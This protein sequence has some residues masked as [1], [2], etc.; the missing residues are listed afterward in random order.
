MRRKLLSRSMLALFSVLV[1]PQVTTA[2]EAPSYARQV[3]PLL[4]KYCVECHNGDK[5][6]GDLDLQTYKSM[7]AGGKK[8]VTIVPGKPDESPLLQRTEGK[9]KPVMPPP[10]SAQPKP[11]EIAVLRAWIAAGA[12]DDGSATVVLPKIKP[13]HL[14]TAPVTAVL[15]DNSGKFLVAG[16]ENWVRLF[17]VAEGT[18]GQLR[19]SVAGSVTAL[20]WEHEDGALAIAGGESG[21]SGELRLYYIPAQVQGVPAHV[22][23]AHDDVIYGLAWSPKGKI[24]ASCGYDRLIKLWDKGAKLLRTLKDHSDTVYGVA[25]SPDGK[26]LASAAA[27]RAVKIW[28]VATGTRLYSLNDSTDWLYAVAWSPDGKHVAAAGVDKSIR[29]WEATASGGKLVHSVFAHEGPVTRL[30]YTSDGKTLYSLSE[31]RSIKSWNTS[32]MTEIKVYDKQPETPLCLAV[33]PDQ[34]QLAVGRYDGALVLL[35]A[36]TGQTQAQPLP[37]KPQPPQLNKLTPAAG[38]RGQVVRVTCEGKNLDDVTELVSSQSG[39]TAKLVAEGQ[40]P[41]TVSFDVTFPAQTPAGSYSLTLK[42]PSGQTSPI[43]FMVDAFPAV[44]EQEPNDSPSTGQQVTLPASIVGSLQRAGDVDFYRFEAKAGQQIGVQVV[45]PAGPKLDPV[46]QL[47]DPAGRIV[48]ESGNGLLGYTCPAAGTYALGIRDQEYRGGSL[49]YRLHVG[50]LP[51]VT[52]VFPLGLQR[53]TEATIRLEGVH[54]GPA[55]TV[56]VNAPA[57]AAPGT[58]IPLT[59]NTPL[60]AALGNPSVVVDE[61][62]QAS[63]AGS[64]L[65]VPTTANGRIATPGAADTWK[66]PAKKGQRLIV[67]VQARRLG[68]PLDSRIEILDAKGQPVPR[69]VLRCLARV[70]TTFRDHDSASPGIRLETWNELAMNDYVLLGN[71]VLRIK[72]LPRNPDDDC[73]FFSVAGQRVGYF[74]TTPTHHSLGS[75]IY[76]LAVHPPG[77]TFPPNGLPVV[78]LYYQNDDGGPGFGK[79]SHLFFDPPADGEY[80]VR[81]TDARGQGGSGY[82]YRLTVRPPR[83]SF[84]VRF[85]P[86]APNVWKGGAVPVTVTADRIDGYDGPIAV[87]LDNLPPGFSAPATTVPAGET[88]TAF[89][90]WANADA[91][92]PAKA[93]L[94]LVARAVIDGTE[95]VRE[96]TGGV[97]E[98]QEPGDIVMTTEQTE[99]TL[100]PGQEVR[101]TAKIE[102]RNG[103]AGRVPLDVRGLPHGVRVLDVGLNGILVTEMDVTRTFVIYCEPWVEPIEHPFVVLARREGKNTEHAAR[104]LLLR[105]TK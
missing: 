3:R 5:M 91:P 65:P 69:A 84:Q 81:L 95:V 86:T 85:N 58:V 2:A 34:K 32:T 37:A 16:S 22:W 12:K 93:P 44:A 51:I 36:A 62:P 13:R 67:E 92:K 43:G 17:I 88:T 90:L 96:V 49:A 102:R 94:K 103:F 82:G 1:L 19:G 23:K 25:F 100:K 73:Q 29:V 53:G 80:Q 78:T 57:D 14:T 8:G 31:D 6:R 77:T 61:F 72:A 10:K 41:A 59:V 28:D 54:L 83:P 42:G 74:G 87:R 11:E 71:E 4:A 79:D 7:L 24:L 33:R 66:F 75:P 55:A 21:S 27:D 50:E 46:L 18:P 30:V 47:T 39:V 52:A 76:K 105:V 63:V 101:V 64:V 40:T 68:A 38:Q 15:Y 35:D 70:Y 97:P 9:L 20:A 48:A 60:G 89:A 99:V 104:S 26:L 98:I 56:A 45:V